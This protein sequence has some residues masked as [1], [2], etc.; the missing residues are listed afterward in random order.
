[1]RLQR[2]GLI[3]FAVYIIFIA[4]GYSQRLPEMRWFNHAFVTLVTGAWLGWRIWKNRNLPVSRLNVAVFALLA[5]GF[6]TV[7]FSDNPRLALEN[8]WLPII[9]TLM[10]FF[11]VNAF[12]YAQHKFIRELLFFV[13]AVLVL[14]SAIQIGSVFFG[15][16]IVRSSG[17][18]W[19]E[20]VGQ[21]I[22]LSLE[23][24]MRIFLPLGVSTQTAGFVAPLIIITLASALG[25]KKFNRILYIILA[26]ILSLILILTFSRGGL[27]SLAVGLAAFFI[28][29]L[30]QFNRLQTFFTRRNIWIAAGLLLFVS[31]AAAG[32]I[33]LSGTSGRTSGDNVRR[34]LWNSATEMITDNPLTGVG[35]GL[36]GR[37][38]RTYRNPVVA[39]DRLSTAHNLYL[40]TTAENGIGVIIILVVSAT[41]IAGSWLRLRN[42]VTI[43]SERWYLLNGMM[44]ALI[45]FAVHNL[46]D[47]L[48]VFGS[49]ALALVMIVHVTIEPAKSRLSPIKAYGHRLGASVLLL[50]VLG[51]GI[52]FIA[53]VDRAH[54]HFINSIR[55]DNDQFAE[56]N[57]AI[58]L[59]PQ[60]NLYRLQLTYLNGWQ[61]YNDP[62]P[63]NLASAIESYE[64]SLL[65]EPTWDTGWLN[66]AALYQL[67]D[68]VAS[69]QN[70]IDQARSIATRSRLDLQWAMISE[71]NDAIP[72]TDV[73]NA[74]IVGIGQMGYLPLSDY[75]AETNL[76]L[77]VLDTYIDRLPADRGYRVNRVHFP[78]RLDTI[79]LSSPET[80]ADWWIAGEQF[81]TVDNDRDAA[82]SAFSNAIDLDPDNGDYYASRARAIGMDD[83]ESAL[84]DLQIARFLGTR[85]EY[86]NIIEANLTTDP[87]E[88]NT[89]RMNA[90]PP[91]G[92]L[93]G[94]DAVVFSGRVAQFVPYD[95]VRI[96]GR[97]DVALQTWYDLAADYEASGDRDAAQQIYR[98]I[99]LHAP[100]DDR[101][102]QAL[103]RLE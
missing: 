41:I 38:L 57:R 99:R 25:A 68:D 91:F 39:D 88:R 44:A 93:Q 90:L 35:T 30:I 60:L 21:G 53:I 102:M 7:P 16:G 9:Y 8:M 32:V 79:I 45:G 94:F 101:A 78:E 85:D 71:Q 42:D 3:L 11:L 50:L 23:P 33:T 95:A 86:P 82:I 73:I 74:Y 66:L 56:I 61:A 54:W 96:I 24:D 36:Y 63:E 55:A 100:E 51:Y 89:L 5:L 26:V 64:N 37:S 48:T 12:H 14:L 22:P 49:V 20:F 67:S 40:N 4:G 87:D 17:Q 6:I 70:A 29:S 62:T 28:L 72:D 31:I 43:H 97:G 13:T 98:L 19:I 52:W 92:L 77:E 59:D 83:R 75:W 10:F 46:F 27:V 80:A 1:M 84:R 69:A 34:D 76:R 103:E 2:I 65:L 58:E 81:L 15:W 18:G 47:T